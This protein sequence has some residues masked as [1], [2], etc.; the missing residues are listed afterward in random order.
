M[1]R[2]VS[3]LSFLR[4]EWMFMARPFGGLWHFLGSGLLW[5]FCTRQLTESVT[6]FREASDAAPRRRKADIE[7]EVK[8]GLAVTPFLPPRLCIKS[9]F[10]T[11]QPGTSG[12]RTTNK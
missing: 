2:I 7:C 10:Q 6:S 12:C 11:R 9:H 4:I 3:S 8:T 5:S 1:L